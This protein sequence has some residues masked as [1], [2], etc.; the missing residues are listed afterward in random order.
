MT[1]TYNGASFAPAVVVASFAA[2]AAAYAAAT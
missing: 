2:P 1:R